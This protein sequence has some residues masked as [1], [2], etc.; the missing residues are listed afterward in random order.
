MT[1]LWIHRLLWVIPVV[2][3]IVVVNFVLVHFAP[4]DPVTTLVGDYPASPEYVAQIRHQFGLDQPLLTQLGLY[5]WNVLHGNLG[6]SFANQQ[7]V[8]TLVSQRALGSLML[9]G[10]ALVLATVLGVVLARLSIG[11]RNRVADEMLNGVTLFGYS[12]PTFWLG[13]ILII[14]FA[15]SLG[16]LPAQGMVSARGVHGPWATFVDFV[17]HWLMPGFCVAIVHLA[18]VTR[19]A[20]ASLREAATQDFVTTARAKGLSARRTFWRHVLPNGLMPVITIIGY[21][22][23]NALTGTVMVETVFA[24]PGLGSLLINSIASRDY[25]VI[26]GVFLFAAFAV[27]LVNLLTDFVYGLL[28]P[29]VRITHVS[30]N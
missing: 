25:P 24:W 29:R 3:A 10:P 15:V 8:M 27:V 28:D 1:R 16:W 17:R 14:A 18:V 30:S 23:G 21:N 26:Q 6:Y 7:S 2:L 5:V 11:G 19:I 13:Q 20:R 12:V 22:F 4:G 9:L